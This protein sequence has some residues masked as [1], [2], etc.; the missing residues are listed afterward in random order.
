M[1]VIH[2]PELQHGFRI[3]TPS[4]RGFPPLI[5]TTAWNFY[6]QR[7][8]LHQAGGLFGTFAILCPLLYMASYTWPDP[9]EHQK[10]LPLNFHSCRRKDRFLTE[11]DWDC[12]NG[13]LTLDDEVIPI[14]HNLALALYYLRSTT[15]PLV[16]WVDAICINQQDLA[17]RNSQVALMSFIYKRAVGVI[18]WLGMP[19]VPSLTHYSTIGD[20]IHAMASLQKETRTVVTALAG[21]KQLADLQFTKELTDDL[22]TSSYWTRLWVV[23]EVCLAREVV[24]AYGGSLWN[25]EQVQ[26]AAF[27]VNA[28]FMQLLLQTREQRYTDSMD[29]STLIERFG[30]H[31]CSQIHDRICALLVL[32]Y[33]TN[34][35]TSLNQREMEKGEAGEILV[36]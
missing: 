10:E 25:S 4:L 22:T 23:Q 6:G 3:P 11:V 35:R 34:G 27:G 31:R 36:D 14:S 32:A 17:E 19:Q 28:Q 16:I 13:R 18:V 1:L 29:L 33:D 24:Y 20:M 5:G 15:N 7:T 8:R 2:T 21:K 9:N 26:E 30:E 12:Y